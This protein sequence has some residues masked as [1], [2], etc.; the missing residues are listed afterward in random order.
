MINQIQVKSYKS[1]VG[2]LLI[3]AYNEQICICDWKYRKMRT[4]IDQRIQSNL[5]ATYIEQSTPIIEQ[6]ITQFEEYFSQKRKV[7]E[8][9]LLLLGTDFQKKVWHQLQQIQYGKTVS[10]LQLSQ[11]MENEKAI[12]AVATANGANAISII[13][14]CHRV[15]GSDGNLTGYAGGLPAKKRLLVL[16]GADLFAQ[17]DLF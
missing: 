11:Q 13:I 12:R 7:F 3:G 8:L 1:P 5:N 10:Y 15:V 16:E 14:P 9:P 17:M 2:E 6:T 4:A